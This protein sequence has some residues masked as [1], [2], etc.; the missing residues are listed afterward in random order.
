MKGEIRIQFLMMLVPGKY[1]CF[2]DRLYLSDAKQNVFL[3][4]F[5][6]FIKKF[7]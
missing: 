3:F 7:S 6:I 1:L 5:N 2:G 4:K